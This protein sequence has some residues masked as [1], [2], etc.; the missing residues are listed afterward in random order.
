MNSLNE[1][2]TKQNPIPQAEQTREI[3][4][5]SD[6][7]SLLQEYIELQALIRM[8]DD[9]FLKKVSKMYENIGE[10]KKKKKKKKKNIQKNTKKKIQKKIRFYCFY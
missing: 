8:D 7:Q 4:V 10:G 2:I 5:F 1:I 9:N 6:L 3:K